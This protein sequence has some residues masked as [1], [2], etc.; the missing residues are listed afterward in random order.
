MRMV[1]CINQ[2]LLW[3]LLFLPKT[4]MSIK[5]FSCEFC[6]TFTKDDVRADSI[7]SSCS[8]SSSV[9]FH[10]LVGLLQ[11]SF[12]F[13]KTSSLFLLTIKFSFLFC[14]CSTQLP[15]S[16]YCSSMMG[17]P[18]N[19]ERGTAKNQLPSMGVEPVMV[20]FSLFSSPAC[21]SSFFFSLWATKTLTLSAWLLP[22]SCNWLGVGVRGVLSITGTDSDRGFR[23]SGT[24][25]SLFL[26]VSRPTDSVKHGTVSPHDCPGLSAA[27]AVRKWKILTN[28]TV[29]QTSTSFLSEA[30]IFSLESVKLKK[31]FH[32]HWL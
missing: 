7:L 18:E 10:D 17:L 15:L 32:P 14:K 13:C 11:T 28:P 3:M 30:F 24:F 22:A 26:E 12:Q 6:A 29:S 31:H 4:P 19:L 25:P 20:R 21:A 1:P 2:S 9:R 8:Y 23:Q 27:T 16:D 5:G